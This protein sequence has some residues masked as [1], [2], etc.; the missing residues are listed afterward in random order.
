MNRK[1]LGALAAYCCVVIAL[2][3]CKAFF[4]I[5]YLWDPANQRRRG[6]SLQPLAEL[7]D[8]QSWFAP[9]FGYGGNIAFFIP[10]GVL[11]YVAF[12]DA[13]WAVLFGFGLSLAVETGQ[14]IFSLGY[15]DID[16][17]LMNTVGTL[18]G[19]GIARRMRPAAAHL[20]DHARLRR[21]TV[22][23]RPRTRRRATRRPLQGHRSLLTCTS[24]AT[25]GFLDWRGRN[26]AL[27]VCC[28]VHLRLDRR[29]HR[30]RL[31]DRGSGV[32]Y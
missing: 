14:Y 16:D 11:A 15:S 10:I 21:A 30:G 1:A 31:R 9:L 4:R 20:L 17:L 23:P 7:H 6:L 28:H 8:A 13:R 32:P 27:S 24:L 25:Y 3:M 12:R 22:L 2:T 26:F 29:Y 5:G 18:V 19:V